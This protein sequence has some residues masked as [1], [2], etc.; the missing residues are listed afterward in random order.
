MGVPE[1]E[2]QAIEGVGRVDAPGAGSGE[3]TVSVQESDEKSPS[4]PDVEKVENDT[5]DEKEKKEKGNAGFAAY[6]VNFHH[7]ED[8]DITGLIDVETVGLCNPF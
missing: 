5:K 2:E 7:A 8:I 1:K 3:K 4:T 6:K